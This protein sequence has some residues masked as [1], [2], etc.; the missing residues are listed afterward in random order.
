M[1]DCT[2]IKVRLQYSSS[3]G[4]IVGSTLNQKDCKIE[5]YDDIYNKVFDIKQE[6]AVAKYVRAYVLQVIVN[7]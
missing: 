7:N 4:C 2:K 6:N 5:T 3:L 1:T